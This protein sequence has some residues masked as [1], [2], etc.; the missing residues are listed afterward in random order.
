[1]LSPVITWIIWIIIKAKSTII[2]PI[3]ALVI[4][5]LP[6]S[7]FLESPLPALIIKVIPPKIKRARR[8]TLA[9]TMEF[10]MIEEIRGLTEP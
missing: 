4:A 10:L 5:D 2:N 3:M 6:C 9:R 1:M 7:A 8:I